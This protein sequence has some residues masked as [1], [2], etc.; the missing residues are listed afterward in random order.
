[1]AKKGLIRDR[2]QVGL[3]N[4][5]VSDTSGFTVA[6]QVI[7]QASADTTELLGVINQFAAAEQGAKV[8][9]EALSAA[10]THS[11]ERDVNGSPI[12]PTEMPSE[13][14]V[15]GKTYRKAMMT[16]Y[17]DQIALDSGMA[18]SD[19][20]T[21]YNMVTD[22]NGNTK[23][24]DAKGFQAASQAY[25]QSTIKNVDPRIRPTVLADLQTKQSQHFNNLLGNYG[26]EQMRSQLA[27][28]AQRVTS[29]N[30]DVFTAASKGADLTTGD[31]LGLVQ[32]AKQAINNG[33]GSAEEKAFNIEKME[34]TAA[35]HGIVAEYTKASKTS[36]SRKEFIV[37]LEMR[38]DGVAGYNPAYDK[39]PK[40]MMNKV[41]VGL[42]NLE[43]SS[44]SIRL[45]KE[46]LAI[47]TF[48][49]VILKNLPDMPKEMQDIVR[50]GKA[51]GVPDSVIL[52]K[53]SALNNQTRAAT[54][55]TQ[56]EATWKTYLD[57]YG[58]RLLELEKSENKEISQLASAALN[59]DLAPGDM[60]GFGKSAIGL[61]E[62]E[63]NE[64]LRKN[65]REEAQ[66][67]KENQIELNKSISA[68]YRAKI[69]EIDIAKYPQT[70]KVKQLLKDADAANKKGDYAGER[71]LLRTAMSFAGQD[72]AGAKIDISETEKAALK[73][74]AGLRH[75]SNI[76]TWR[77]TIANNQGIMDRNPE[78][79][80]RV[81]DANQKEVSDADRDSMLKT[82]AVSI[83]SIK[84]GEAANAA[85]V[86][87]EMAA[88]YKKFEG[89]I[90]A[91]ASGTYA[92]PSKNNAEGVDF[93]MQQAGIDP[94]GNPRGEGMRI[95]ALAGLPTKSVNVLKSVMSSSDPKVWTTAVSYFRILNESRAVRTHMAAQA[96]SDV[97]GMLTSLDMKMGHGPDAVVDSLMIQQVRRDEDPDAPSSVQTIAV[98]KQQFRGEDLTEQQGD[99]AFKK[100][101][102]EAIIGLQKETKQETFSDKTGVAAGVVTFASFISTMSAESR[103]NRIGE[104]LWGFKQADHAGVSNLFFK[105]VENEVYSNYSRYQHSNKNVRMQTALK[106]AIHS[107]MGGGKYGFSSVSTAPTVKSNGVLS[108]VQYPPEGL[109]N[110]PGQENWVRQYAEDFIASSANAKQIF[111]AHGRIVLGDNAYLTHIKD[112]S[113]KHNYYITS[114][115]NGNYKGQVFGKDNKYLM[116]NFDAEF[117]RRKAVLVED[118]QA[119]TPIVDA[120]TAFDLERTRDDVVDPVNDL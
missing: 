112:N 82:V 93:V 63:A 35:A 25:I 92:L 71:T 33:R 14:T 21:S 9:S 78:L 109:Y 84:T 69:G 59:K 5:G 37:G 88:Q 44:Q 62:K 31:A 119:E 26:K 100:L 1:M 16:K 115:S 47:E 111:A 87:K 104:A 86:R 53:I 11:I 60:L 38:I 113:G 85:R 4:I 73:A 114:S 80:A 49:G 10:A 48:Q 105:E 40:E 99:D 91:Y 66:T 68:S 118:A 32:S 89:A 79:K 2:Q 102:N 103:V 108:I 36:V 12:L 55:R 45:E 6:R 39:I 101:F 110:I 58:D 70:D 56:Q 29:A 81:Y 51:D 3:Q 41:I 77:F 19:I 65:A 20:A 106:N 90:N 23:M 30:N 8:Q 116:I 98:A 74:S 42:K 7:T 64:T 52:G 17:A 57:I 43:G 120:A 15:Y 50:Q 107:V 76:E 72:E 34:T 67:N 61:A 13:Y 46:R 24:F 22:K 95:M 27:V 18:L 75:E 83:N 117:E 96:G 97:M 94:V 54:G 28:H